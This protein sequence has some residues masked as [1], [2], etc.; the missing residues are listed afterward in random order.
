[1]WTDHK[2]I[3]HE[4]KFSLICGRESLS[5]TKCTL[6]IVPFHGTVNVPCFASD[7]F[8]FGLIFVP[9]GLT[10]VSLAWFVFQVTW[11]CSMLAWALFPIA[12]PLFPMAWPLFSMAWPFFPTAWPLF[13]MAWPLFPMAWPL[14]PRTW[15][16][17]GL[18]D[19][20]ESWAV[21]CAH[22][23][24]VARLRHIVPQV[25]QVRQSENPRVTVHFLYPEAGVLVRK[26]SQLT[27][28]S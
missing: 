1:M 19:P 13:S 16:L 15:P 8:Q 7:F 17:F 23:E 10:F 11:N 18:S 28:L 22:P 2:V 5:E 20:D 27:P 3:I 4:V 24:L 26:W 25:L 12:W 6:Y 14:F 21:G 9:S